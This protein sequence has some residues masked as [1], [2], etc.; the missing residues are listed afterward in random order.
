MG[1][2]FNISIGVFFNHNFKCDVALAFICVIILILSLFYI[3]F[4]FNSA[5]MHSALNNAF[6]E[7]IT[8]KRL[9]CCFVESKDVD[10]TKQQITYT[11]PVY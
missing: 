2:F 8:K 7:I 1:F 11:R 4:F 10:K 6:M 5:L 9:N 3:F